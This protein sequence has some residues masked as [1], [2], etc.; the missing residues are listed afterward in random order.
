M[1]PIDADALCEWLMNPTGFPANCEDCCEIDCV[2]CIVEEAIRNAPT[3]DYAPVRQGEWVLTESPYAEHEEAFD[4]ESH[5]R[6]TCSLCG[7][8]AG[9]ECD[10]DGFAGFQEK[11]KFCGHCGAK[12][13]GGEKV[14]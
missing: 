7:G 11:T 4:G 2:E 13:D 1:R 10:P 8:E 14:G 3:L 5:D 6:W 12:M 9:F